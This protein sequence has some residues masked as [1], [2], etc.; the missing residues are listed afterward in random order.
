MCKRFIATLLL[1]CCCGSVFAGDEVDYSAP[2]MTLENGELVTK[3]PAKEHDPNAPQANTAPA[4]TKG[5]SPTM[6]PKPTPLGMVLVA[7]LIA[8]AVYLS[9]SSTTK[10]QP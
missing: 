2:Y 7:A 3:Y 8:L 10:T 5:S 6:P 9:R 4:G 1:A